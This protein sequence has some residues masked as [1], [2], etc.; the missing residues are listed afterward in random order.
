MSSWNWQSV[1]FCYSTNSILFFSRK[2]GLKTSIASMVVHFSTVW[3]FLKILFSMCFNATCIH[4][5]TSLF[6]RIQGEKIEN[7]LYHALN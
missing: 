7:D 2:I 1:V 4:L 6:L 3:I 5:F